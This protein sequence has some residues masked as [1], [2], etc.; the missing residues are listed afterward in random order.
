MADPI[1]VLKKILDAYNS[2]NKK[3]VW[4]LLSPGVRKYYKNDFDLFDLYHFKKK[5]L[6]VSGLEWKLAYKGVKNHI[7]F[8]WKR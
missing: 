4:R 3:S 6:F 8:A 2:D 7:P 5:K 1:Y